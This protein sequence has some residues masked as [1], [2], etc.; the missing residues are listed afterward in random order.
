M[1]DLRGVPGGVGVDLGA[2]HVVLGVED[3]VVLLE[4]GD[5]DDRLGG[6]LLG[7][8][9]AGL[10]GCPRSRRGRRDGPRVELAHRR[11]GAA[12]RG[13]DGHLELEGGVLGTPD[14]DC[15]AVANSRCSAERASATA[16]YDWA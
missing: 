4:L 12:L 5:P 3:V 9:S 10:A 15:M 2:E 6:A 7:V 14:P 11:G 8:L 1:P 16:R 13:D